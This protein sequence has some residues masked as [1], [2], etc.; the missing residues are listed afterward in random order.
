MNLI[1]V[2]PLKQN[3][4]L[5]G[6]VLHG[7]KKSDIGFYG[8]G[9][10][11]FSLVTYG[12]VKAWKRHKEMVMNL[13]VPVGEVRFVFLDQAGDLMREEI[14]G[15][16]NYVRLTVSQGVWFGFQGLF[17]T[18][19]LVVNIANIP[20]DPMESERASLDKFS[21]KWEEL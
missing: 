6:N 5:G 2:T 16:R 3:P 7:I 8:F 17:P 18:Q 20:H 4:T 19:S 9:E 14:I 12:S 10:T 1:K 11:Y 15:S 21:Y 13:I